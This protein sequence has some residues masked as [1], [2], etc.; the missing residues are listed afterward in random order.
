MKNIFLFFIIQSVVFL[1]LNSHSAVIQHN[2]IALKHI[3]KISKFR[4]GAGHD[5]SYDG[6]L[7]ANGFYEVETDPTE[8]NRSMKHY[9]HVIEQYRETNTTIPIYAPFDGTIHRV[10][11]DSHWRGFTDKQVWIQSNANPNYYAVIFHVNLSDTF[12]QA[13]NDY[14]QNLWPYWEPNDSQYLKITMQAGEIIGF[15]D[16]RQIASS[17]IAI[18]HKVSGQEYHYLSFFDSAVMPYSVFQEFVDKGITSQ[19]NLIFSKDYRDANPIPENHQWDGYT[20]DD[21]VDLKSG[22]V[23]IPST[24]LL[25]LKYDP[26]KGP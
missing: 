14:P 16:T 17:D 15:A 3:E 6:D 23:I 7:I 5:F 1:A 4:S 13:W 25:L 21:W 10:S 20:P 22:P 19:S 24:R 18:L 11:N 26:T 8:T 12:P 9:F 2:Y